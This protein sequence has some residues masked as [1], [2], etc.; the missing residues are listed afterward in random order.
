ME[1]VIRRATN[2][3]AEII[4][5]LNRDVQAIHAAALPRRFKPPG[6]DTFPPSE[7]KALLAKPE[8]VLFLAHCGSDPA[9]YA[10]V[11]I[12]RR[13]ETSLV[14]AYE[15]IYL[16]HMSVAEAFRNQG[17]GRSLL[18][19]VRKIGAELGI[20]A[21]ALDVWSFNEG[22]RSFF[23]RYGLTAYNERMWNQ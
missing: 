9:G 14:H 15:T 16:H 13:A 2:A 8:N 20:T 23:R 5:V 1:I 4:S 10:Y 21:L 6:P 18:D 3:D 22:A 7:V 12:M 11:E 19:A 17:V